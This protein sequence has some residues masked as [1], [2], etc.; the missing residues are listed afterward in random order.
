MPI[1]VLNGIRQ[2]PTRGQVLAELDFF[3]RPDYALRVRRTCPSFRVD[4]FDLTGGFL[5]GGSFC[6]DRSRSGGGS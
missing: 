3:A 4:C 5:A 6:G 2:A 1:S